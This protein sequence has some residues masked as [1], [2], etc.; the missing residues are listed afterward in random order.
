MAWTTPKTWATSDPLNATN[1]NTYIRD[2]QNFLH[3]QTYWEQ[4]TDTSNR[5]TTSSSWAT[6][7]AG[8]AITYTVNASSLIL[9]ILNA[10]VS[11]DTNSTAGDFRIT[12]GTNTYPIGT[13]TRGTSTTQQFSGVA[14]ITGLSGSTT[15]T[16]Q[17]RSIS[18]TG[19]ISVLGATATTVLELIEF[20]P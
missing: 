4:D 5:T 1:L 13:F 12:D 11:S 6:I 18:N 17:F 7:A 14:V 16:P 9:V 20:I 10:T 8:F 15:F 3:N 19:T 2:N